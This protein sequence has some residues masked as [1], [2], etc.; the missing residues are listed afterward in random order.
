MMD[1][2]KEEKISVVINTYNA[3]R[4]LKEVL[5]AVSGFDEV[6]VCDM[7]SQDNTR[8][9]AKRHG[10]KVVTFPRKNFSICEPARQCA[11]DAATN[12]WILVVDADEV[13]SPELRRYLYQLTK[14]ANAPK[15]LYIPRK[16]Y[17]MGKFM[18]CFYPDYQLRFF[19]KEGTYWPPVI[20]ANPSIQGEVDKIPAERTDLALNHLADGSVACR[21]GKIN[22]YTENEVEKKKNKHYGM[23]A[24]FYRPLVRFFRAYIQKGGF[25]DGKAGLVCACYEG[26]YQFAAVS[27][28]IEHRRMACR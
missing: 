19:V 2:N 10:C 21:I 27:K 17:F 23:L 22:Q 4:H 18:H 1:T 11:I 12:K 8:E 15:G 13:V 5:D 3:A 26:I 28:M 7:E 6:V 25:R 20:H 14:E 9:I 24:L 16:S